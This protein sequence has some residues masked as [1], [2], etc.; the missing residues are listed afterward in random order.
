VELI[1]DRGDVAGALNTILTEP[2]YG[3][4]VDEAKVSYMGSRSSENAT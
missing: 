2:P 4:G 3:D 1:Y